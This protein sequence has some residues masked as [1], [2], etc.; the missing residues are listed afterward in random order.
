MKKNFLNYSS[1]RRAMAIPIVLAFVGIL[2]I[3]VLALMKSDRQDQP[4]SFSNLKHLQMKFIAKGALQHAR[5]KMQLL[6]TQAYD[7]AAYAVGKNPLYDHGAGYDFDLATKTN[8][9]GPNEKSSRST[10][11]GFIVTNPGPA[12]L[13]GDV[14]GFSPLDRSA[15]E[16]VNFDGGGDKWPNYPDSQT[17]DLFKTSSQSE[18]I[19][20]LYLVRFYEDIST[21]DPFADDPPVLEKAINLRNWITNGQVTANGS[22]VPPSTNWSLIWP[23]SQAAIAIVSGYADPVTGV[24]SMFTAS[25]FVDEMRVLATRDARLYAQEAIKVGVKV[26]MATKGFVGS[27]GDNDTGK[28]LYTNVDGSLQEK[29]VFKVSRTLR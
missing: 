3:T 1:S 19:S 18:F 11:G 5:L 2:T 28:A 25:Y 22:P 27:E 10:A 24:P 9:L 23:N 17:E 7:A 13:T 15:V 16:D 4:M 21:T 20:N 8:T 12:F 26:K 14:N 29:A 6:S